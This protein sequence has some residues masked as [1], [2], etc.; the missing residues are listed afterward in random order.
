MPYQLVKEEIHA[1]CGVC[2][3]EGEIYADDLDNVII[4]TDGIHTIQ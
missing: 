2:D 4:D 3:S 1:Q